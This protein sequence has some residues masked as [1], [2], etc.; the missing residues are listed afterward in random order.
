MAGED[1]AV[2][3]LLLP[4]LA[5]LSRVIADKY[6]N[7]NQGMASVDDV[8]QETFTEAYRQIQEFDPKKGSLRTWLATN[9][10]QFF[11]N[12]IVALP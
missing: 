10:F 4:H 7:L 12:L 3:Q 11:G 8:I 9:P 2:R 6:P 5:H 1:L